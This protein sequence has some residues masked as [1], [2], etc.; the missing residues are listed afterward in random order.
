MLLT[1]CCLH[2]LLSII[3]AHDQGKIFS[4]VQIYRAGNLA[5]H[6]PPA[7][8]GMALESVIDRVISLVHVAHEGTSVFEAMVWE[9]QVY[10]HRFVLPSHSVVSTM[11]PPTDSCVKCDESCG[12]QRFSLALRIEDLSTFSLYQL[13]YGNKWPLMISIALVC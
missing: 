10:A 8:A 12:F 3:I 2:A 9:A 4:P 13:S 1:L 5:G 6:V 7:A 11:A